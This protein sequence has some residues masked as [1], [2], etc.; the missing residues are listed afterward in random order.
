VVE[1]NVGYHKL[2][3]IHWPLILFSGLVL[4]GVGKVVWYEGLKRLD[5][6]KAISLAITFPLFSLFVLAFFFGETITSYQ[7]VGIVM[8]GIGV[9]FSV[10]RKSVD[11]RQTRYLMD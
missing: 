7:W 6:S 9:Y 8:M 3:V 5:I 4:L 10:K 1:R 11:I 2:V